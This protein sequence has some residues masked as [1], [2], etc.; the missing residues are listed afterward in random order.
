[1]HAGGIPLIRAEKRGAFAE[2]EIA[3]RVGV[4]IG[5]K[6]VEVRRATDVVVEVLVKVRLAVSIDIVKVRD[7]I[8]PEHVDL[9][10]H[11]LD[12]PNGW[13]RP[14]CKAAPIGRFLQ[15]VVDAA[16][17]PD[18]AAPRADSGAFPVGEKVE[19]AG[20]HPSVPGILLG[21]RKGIHFVEA[22][23]VAEF[24]LVVMMVCG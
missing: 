24:A 14:V 8:A 7:L 15:L 22:A 23:F 3:L 10:V 13:K 16:H 6:L 2:I 11:D 5:R 18:I 19:T 17:D 1:M 4:E 21:Q 12:G 20:A 9:V